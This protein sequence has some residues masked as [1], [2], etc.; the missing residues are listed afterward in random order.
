[1]KGGNKRS[2][3]LNKGKQGGRMVPVHAGAGLQGALL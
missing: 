3:E 1:M 2:G